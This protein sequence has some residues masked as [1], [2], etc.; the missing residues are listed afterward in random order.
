MRS[1]FAIFNKEKSP[2]SNAFTI[3]ILCDKVDTTSSNKTQLGNEALATSVD[4]SK[5]GMRKKNCK[6]LATSRLI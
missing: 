4:N 2:F 3:K 1:F 5:L 6:L